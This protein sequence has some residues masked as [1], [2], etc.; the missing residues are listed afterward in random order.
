MTLEVGIQSANDLKNVEFAGVS[1]PYVVLTIEGSSKSLLRTPA[2][3]N[4]LNPVWFFTGIAAWDG[5]SDLVFTVYDSNNLADKF[6]GK[7]TLRK[8]QADEGFKGSLALDTVGTL[9]V[10]VQPGK[11]S[12]S[13]VLGGGLP[14]TN[15]VQFDALVQN[16]LFMWKAPIKSAS[17]LVGINVTFLLYFFSAPDLLDLVSKL[18]LLG[19]ALGAML[20]LGGVQINQ[21]HANLISASSLGVVADIVV[22]FAMKGTGFAQHIIS[23]KSQSDTVKVLVGFYVLGAISGWISI[24]SL[25]F[26]VANLLFILP[27]QLEARKAF[28]ENKVEPELIKLRVLK[29]KV[30]SLIPKYDDLNLAGA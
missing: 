13:V 20:K 7:A 11:P 17:V 8:E 18:G 26:T 6:M 29:A 24:F 3:N 4:N 15:S 23:W 28:I 30:I 27:V 19:I 5:T 2:I 16:E 9:L 14:R 25:A 12:A 1:D 22:K 10:N 21:A